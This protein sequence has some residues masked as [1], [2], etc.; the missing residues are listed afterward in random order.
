ME[1]WCGVVGVQ[2]SNVPRAIWKSEESS[3]C[4]LSGSKERRNRNC[5]PSS[6]RLKGDLEP[7]VAELQ[8][9]GDPGPGHPCAPLSD[10]KAHAVEQG[11]SP[12]TVHLVPRVPGRGEEKGGQAGTRLPHAVWVGTEDGAEP[13]LLLKW[14]RPSS[15]E[16]SLHQRL[17]QFG[18][19]TFSFPAAFILAVAPS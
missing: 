11:C 17:A 9:P 19:C 13:R 1:N 15:P 4:V 5:A 8:L 3:S 10:Y 7:R 6:S 16:A 12:P 2:D 14:V 18:L